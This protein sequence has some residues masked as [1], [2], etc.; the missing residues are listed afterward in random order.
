[1][2]GIK[3]F[4]FVIYLIIESAFFILP[5]STVALIGISINALVTKNY[6]K[7]Y[8]L[9]E[10]FLIL[11]TLA[12]ASLNIESRFLPID[13]I[14]NNPLILVS[15]V[16]ILIFTLAVIIYLHKKRNLKFLMPVAA[17]VFAYLIYEIVVYWSNT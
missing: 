17:F 14:M 2:I 9:Y 12:I 6:E 7:F 15:A 3:I 4:L 11:M 8:K 10:I 1:M 5:I 13:V 16:W